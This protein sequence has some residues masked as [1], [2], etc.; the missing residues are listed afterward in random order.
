M[1]EKRPLILISNDDSVNALGIKKLTEFARDFGDVVVVAPDRGHSGQSHA[2][3]MTKPLFFNLLQQEPGLKIYSC[4]GSPADSVKM[5]VHRVLDR[6]PDL[7]ISGINHGSNSSTSVFYS[8]TMAAAI[9]GSLNEIPSV[10]FSLLD[11]SPDADFLPGKPYIQ[12]IIQDV[13]ENGLPRRTCLNVN[14]PKGNNIKGTKVCRQADGAWAEDF[15]KASHPRG[16]EYYWLT[17]TFTNH[18][19]QATDTDEYVLQ[20]GYVSVVPV[21]TDLT[22]YEFINQLSSRL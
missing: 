13:L 20:Q 11:Y 8:G 16:F 19:P 22:H 21:Y 14:I 2:V 10:G 1:T 17:G 5:A 3:T 4:N 18:E 15:Y 6:K 9:E 12:K 7:L